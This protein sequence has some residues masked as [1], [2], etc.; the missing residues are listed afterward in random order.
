VRRIAPSLS[1]V[2]V[3]AAAIAAPAAL[4]GGFAT[5]GLNSTPDGLRAGE[6]WKVEVTVLAHGRTPAAGLKPRLRLEGP[7][8][9]RREVGARPTARAGV[10]AASVRFPASGRWSYAVFDGYND[11]M[12]TTFAPVTI[13]PRAGAP[14]APPSSPADDGGPPV[15]PLVAGGAALV[16]AGGAL[17]LCRR[18]RTG[19][20]PA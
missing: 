12:P 18:R 11:A 14:A 15:W 9:A 1:A 5:T 8:G 16:L 2:A 6:P 19:A 7:G 17:A 10:Y 20:L 4:G 3:A 13:G